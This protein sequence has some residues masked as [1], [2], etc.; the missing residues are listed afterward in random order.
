MPDTPDITD[1]K[2][3]RL[4][5]KRDEKILEEI[6]KPKDELIKNFQEETRTFIDPVKQLEHEERKKEW[7]LEI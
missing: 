7:D 5:K 3:N 2:V 6:L 1:I 4:S